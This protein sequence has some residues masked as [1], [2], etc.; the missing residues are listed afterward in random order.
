MWNAKGALNCSGTPGSWGEQIYE[1]TGNYLQ[2]KPQTENSAVYQD[3]EGDV[4]EEAG[5]L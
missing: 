1:T 4:A 3:P 5:H 2:S